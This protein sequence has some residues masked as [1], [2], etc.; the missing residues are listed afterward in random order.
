[1]RYPNLIIR[2]DY[3][4][5]NATSISKACGKYEIDVCGIVKG[6]RSEPKVAKSMLSGGVKQIGDA[7]LGNLSNLKKAGITAPLLLTRIPMLSEVEQLIDAADFS[8]NSEMVTI[9]AINNV[10]IQKDKSHKVVLMCDLGDLREGFIDKASLFESALKIE[11]MVGVQLGG[12]GTNLGCYGSVKPTRENLSELV[13]LART[14]E[15]QIGRTLEIVSGGATSTLPMVYDGSIPE[16]IN[17]LRIGEGI[18]L[19]RDLP[20][21]WDVPLPSTHKDTVVIEAQIVELKRKPS[22]PIGEIFIDAFGNRPTYE[23]RG[24]ENRAIIA[25]GRQD[26]AF[27]DQ[28]IPIDGRV[29]L[30]GS[31]SDHLIVTVPD[32]SDYV[33]GDVIAFEMYYGPMLFL[34]GADH[35]QK[36]YIK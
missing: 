29:K 8:L 20:D 12:I 19:A 22:H 7:R 33:V 21:I 15:S 14:I 25:L 28:L 31:S 17:H 11:N 34:S 24:H 32:T 4:E 13:E 5:E 3:I 18:L 35:I 1:M 2:L 16:G 36:T 6:I 23:D 26:F 30:I 9:E 27:M 10:C